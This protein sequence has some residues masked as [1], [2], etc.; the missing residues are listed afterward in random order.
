MK[1]G[2]VGALRFGE[3]VICTIVTVLKVNMAVAVDSVVGV[4]SD[5]VS[6]DLILRQGTADVAH[7]AVFSGEAEEYFAGGIVVVRGVVQ[8][9]IVERVGTAGV[10]RV[11]IARL[12]IVHAHPAGVDFVGVDQTASVIVNEIRETLGLVLVHVL[13]HVVQ[14]PSIQLHALITVVVAGEVIRPL[15]IGRRG[16]RG[17][18]VGRLAAAI[19]TTIGGGIANAQAVVGFRAIFARIAEIAALVLT[20]RIGVIPIRVG[21]A[22]VVDEVA[23]I[24]DVAISAAGQ[25]D[26]AAAAAVV[27][28]TT[29]AFDRAAV[30]IGGQVVRSV[31]IKVVVDITTALTKPI[32]T[33]C[34]EERGDAATEAADSVCHLVG[35]I[36]AIRPVV[37]PPSVCSGRGE[38]DQTEHHHECQCE[39]KNS[40]FHNKTSIF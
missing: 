36:L 5:S 23:I 40:L 8:I 32:T 2:F 6:I 38:A 31:V 26:G 28:I 18:G 37:V 15:R 9:R 11:E 17:V 33:G 21:Q 13:P 24:G 7:A 19:V 12:G 14:T 3:G 16:G 1:R 4:V 39:G 10:S 25:I 30:G 35:N 20:P 34:C 27:A 29:D 22:I